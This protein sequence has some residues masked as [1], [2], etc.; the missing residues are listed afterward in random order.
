MHTEENGVREDKGMK[1]ALCLGI[2]RV[3]DPLEASY[4]SA[5]RGSTWPGP[6]RGPSGYPG[7]VPGWGGPMTG[8][9]IRGPGLV[10]K[11]TEG[12]VPPLRL[13]PHS[14]QNVRQTHGGPR[15]GP[16]EGS[17]ETDMSHPIILTVQRVVRGLGNGLGTLNSGKKRHGGCR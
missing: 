15:T 3:P 7:P 6:T 14:V 2:K 13:P 1:S 10:V 8:K 5:G 11:D 9:R 4:V 16:T 17:G 12:S